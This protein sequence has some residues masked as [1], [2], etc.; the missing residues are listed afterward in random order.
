MPSEGDLR[1]GHGKG[2]LRNLSAFGYLWLSVTF[3][4]AHF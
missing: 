4:N 1:H 2:G 3:G